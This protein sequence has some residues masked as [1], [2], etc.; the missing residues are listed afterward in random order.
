MV[1]GLDLD[2][3]VVVAVESHHAGVVAKHAHAPVGGAQ[4]AAD[5]LRGREHRL[6]EEVGVADFAGRA[7]VGHRAGERLVA[8][9]LAPGLGD[10]LELDLERVAAEPAEVVADG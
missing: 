2:A 7:R 9:V 4:P 5:L 8:A 3:D 10:R 6:L 1:V